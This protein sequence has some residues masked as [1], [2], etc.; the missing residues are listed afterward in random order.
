MPVIEQVSLDGSYGRDPSERMF[1]YGGW[2]GYEDAW[3]VLAMKWPALLDKFNIHH[4]RSNDL[5]GRPDWKQLQQEFG[6]A[7]KTAGLHVV[8]SVPSE[9]LLGSGTEAQR[10]MA[11]FQHV[12]RQL[13]DAAPESVNFALMCDREQDLE[14]QISA[15]VQR[16]RERKGDQY[17]RIVGVC[18][19]N[20]KKVIHV[21]AADL[22]ANLAR[23]QGE[24][25]L[26]NQAAPMDPL[27]D[28]LTDGRFSVSYVSDADFLVSE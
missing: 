27:L 22:V 9:R 2:F 4:F 3:K 12:V 15:W 21:Q 20:S 17:D 28:K 1:S 7:A 5:K 8:V 16:L 25:L 23:E 18:F 11:V 13:F 24:A 19:L 6:M 26:R 14:K 10:K